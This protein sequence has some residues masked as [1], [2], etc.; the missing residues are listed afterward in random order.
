[1]IIECKVA[2]LDDHE[3]GIEECKK[4]DKKPDECINWLNSAEGMPKSSKDGNDRWYLIL[5]LM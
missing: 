1:V 2:L 4:A 5:W 3:K